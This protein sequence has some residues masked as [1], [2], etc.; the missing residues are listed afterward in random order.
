M[1]PDEET[2]KTYAEHSE[3]HRA[4]TED[5]FACEGRKNVR[6]R[7]HARKDG[8]VNLRVTEEPEEMLPENGRAAL[9]VD[10]LVAHDEAARN[11][12]ARSG[13]AIKKKQNARRQKHRESQE[14]QHSRRKP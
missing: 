4:I 14:R 10:N 7:A 8:Y 3:D 2:Q 13:V 1:S 9:V 12:E 11:E 6:G 5:G